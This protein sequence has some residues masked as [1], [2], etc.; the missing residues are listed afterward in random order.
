SVAACANDITVAMLANNNDNN[1]LVNKLKVF[2]GT[3]SFIS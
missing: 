1:F 3:V 2:F